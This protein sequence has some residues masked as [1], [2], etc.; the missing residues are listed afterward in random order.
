MV[1]DAFTRD[2][3]EYWTV[4]DG[5]RIRHGFANGAPPTFQI[6]PDQVKDTLRRLF[7]LPDV[8][9]GW[10]VGLS[11][12]IINTVNGGSTWTLLHHFPAV[13]P[14]NDGPDEDLYDVHFLDSMRGWVVGKRGIWFTT[15]GGTSWGSAT[16]RFSNGATVTPPDFA[17]KHIELYSLDIVERPNPVDPLLPP[18]LLGLAS[19]EPGYVFRTTDGVFWDQVLNLDKLCVNPGQPGPILL[20]CPRELDAP[21][22]ESWG[23]K[24]SRHPTQTLAL[25][26]GGYGFGEGH[27]FASGDDGLTWVEEFH[28]CTCTGVSGCHDCTGDPLYNHQPGQTTPNR[29]QSFRTLYDVSIFDGDNSAVAVGYNGQHLIRNPG[30]AGT[31]VWVDRSEFNED[32]LNLPS[33][34]Q[35]V[36]PL[37]GTAANAGAGTQRKCLVTGFGGHI[38]SSDQVGQSW[39]NEV[40]GEPFRIQNI[41]F[42]DLSPFKSG[43]QMGQF[44]RIAST[45]DGGST[46]T[47]ATPAPGR[48]LPNL[49]AMI[50]ASDQLHGVAVGDIDPND[51]YTPQRPKILST[52][53][54]A[55]SG[56]WVNSTPGIT[57][58][59]GFPAGKLMDVTWVGGQEFFAAGDSGLILRSQDYGLTWRNIKTNG[60]QYLDL[61]FKGVAFDGTTTGILV[62]KSVTGPLGKAFQLKMGVGSNNWTDLSPAD[63]D[64]KFIADVAIYNH[65]AYAVGERIDSVTSV[66]TG[67]VFVSTLSGGNF[68]QFT[69]MSPQPLAPACQAGADLGNETN[70]GDPVSD[71]AVLNQIAIVPSTGV[72]W[73]GGECGRVWRYT[74]GSPGSWVEYKSQTD[75]H[76]LGISP[77][78]GEGFVYFG[79]YRFMQT[80][81]CIVRYLP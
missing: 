44:F 2:G 51:T 75:T 16:L 30:P 14:A 33:F 47:A 46:W 53:D 64:V 79:G 45:I 8:P 74:P 40:L 3:T 10:A 21:N 67:L 43:W 70:P 4:E 39:H 36:Y 13:L 78:N 12:W 56:F 48:T 55:L 61:M 7:F 29:L 50:F 23:I 26:L 68:G 25:M 66:K 72:M 57:L 42:R 35:V 20:T 28:E 41:R 52:P 17:S 22:F 60:N 71:V 11:G 62:G 37:L 27:A 15:N 6:V 19:S 80:L 69:P 38:R 9:K 31:V 73:V 32:Y 58:T 81:Q 18:T 65:K 54:N 5:G 76:I 24:I 59:G 1:F 34:A 77:V 49:R 63:P